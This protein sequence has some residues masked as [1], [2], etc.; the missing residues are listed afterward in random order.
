MKSLD[1]IIATHTEP[2]TFKNQPVP[3]EL[4]A[5]L[6]NSSRVTPYAFYL[7]PTH[8]YVITEDAIK[9]KIS[10]ACFNSPLIKQAPLVVIF[11][12]DRFAP[13]HQEAILDGALEEKELTVDQAEKARQALQLHFDVSPI[14]LGWLGKLL[15]APII[16]LFTTMPQIP[17]VHK[18]EFLCRQVMRSVMT[19][20]WAAESNGLNA[21]IVESYDEWRIKW[22]LNIP[23]HHIVVSVMLVGYAQDKGKTIT[24]LDSSE[25]VHWNKT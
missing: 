16:R 23:W 1:E 6:I 12:G 9:E 18:R 15:G 25:V 10:K 14:G 4:I 13:K 24:P 7:Q 3:E 11:T 22:A 2:L 17:A 20:F 21:R 8:Y 5:T 19:F